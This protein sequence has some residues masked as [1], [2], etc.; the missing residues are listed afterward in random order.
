MMVI[1]LDQRVVGHIPRRGLVA[2]CVGAILLSTVLGLGTQ[3]V[4]GTPGAGV[5]DANYDR[6]VRPILS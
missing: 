3:A 4:G 6:T 5:P 2:L 1:R